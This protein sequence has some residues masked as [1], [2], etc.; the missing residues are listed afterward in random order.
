MSSAI[1][2]RGRWV[3]KSSFDTI[4]SGSRVH[5]YIIGHGLSIKQ[6]I[7]TLHMSASIGVFVIIVTPH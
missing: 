5:A 7:M 6:I 2:S 3:N 4:H 1:L